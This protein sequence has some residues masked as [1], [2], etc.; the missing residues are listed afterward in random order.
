METAFATP[1]STSTTTAQTT[2]AAAAAPAPS[3][4][5]PEQLLN[6]LNVIH[7]NTHQIVNQLVAQQVDP[8]KAE[9]DELRKFKNDNKSAAQ[10]QGLVGVA[11]IEKLSAGLSKCATYADAHEALAQFGNE[12]TRA[13]HGLSG[14]DRRQWNLDSIDMALIATGFIVVT[15]A[16][17]VTCWKMG[18]SS[19]MQKAEHGML[20]AGNGS[21]AGLA[22]SRL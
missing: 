16:V 1:A 21:Y 5:T 13:L 4:F 15:G 12:S 10:L 6:I 18:E 8:V 3:A 17:G 14:T 22:G 19:G 2:A 20:G 7:S 11:N 9:L